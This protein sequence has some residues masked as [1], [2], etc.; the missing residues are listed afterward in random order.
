MSSLFTTRTMES[1]TNGSIKRRNVSRMSQGW[2]Y[3]GAFHPQWI[4]IFN[5]IQLKQQAVHI[6]RWIGVC[7]TEQK[8]VSISVEHAGD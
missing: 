7:Q 4:S 8:I 2:F 6:S 3:E 1:E 5:R